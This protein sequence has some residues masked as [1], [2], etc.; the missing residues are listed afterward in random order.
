[1]CHGLSLRCCAKS[2]VTGGLGV[3]ESLRQSSDLRR[4]LHFCPVS[5]P[6]PAAATG[7]VV[8]AS[9]TDAAARYTTR[10]LGKR[11]DGSISPLGLLLWWPYHLG[12]QI[13]LY[14]RRT[15]GTEPLFHQV[16]PGWCGVRPCAAPQSC[17]LARA[18]LLSLTALYM[19]LQ[20]PRRVAA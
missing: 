13:R 3:L 18:C 12:L 17:L 19:H 10:L 2:Q 9:A 8:A 4:A 5:Q 16:H 11:E 14:K 15:Y 1:M 6:L 20:V 7:F